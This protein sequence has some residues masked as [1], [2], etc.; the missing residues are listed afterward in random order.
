MLYQVAGFAGLTFSMVVA[1]GYLFLTT[2][3]SDK[4]PVASIAAGT[5]L[6]DRQEH[7]AP[8]HATLGD[9]ELHPLRIELPGY[10]PLADVLARSNSGWLLNTSLL[11]RGSGLVVDANTGR[12]FQLTP[13]QVR[14]DLLIGRSDVDPDTSGLY[15]AF[16]N[17][18]RSTWQPLRTLRPTARRRQP[19]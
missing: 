16:V 6:I 4:V 17:G 5:I 3:V 18:N 1:L 15:V 19:S 10:E 8:L 2:S 14:G 12:V 7:E 9:G 13:A 11:T